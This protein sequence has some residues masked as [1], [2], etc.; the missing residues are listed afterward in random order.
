MQ[1]N[2]KEKNGFAGQVKDYVDLIE[3]LVYP[4]LSDAARQFRI[5]ELGYG[6][7]IGD[8][9]FY[10]DYPYSAGVDKLNEALADSDSR[11]GD[12]DDGLFR[13]FANL[14]ERAGDVPQGYLYYTYDITQEGFRCAPQTNLP[15]Q[16]ALIR[17]QIALFL[18][19]M[20]YSVYLE[21]DFLAPVT[22]DDQMEGPR[23][24]LYLNKILPDITN[25]KTAEKPHVLTCALVSDV[26]CTDIASVVREVYDKLYPM[27][28]AFYES[29]LLVKLMEE[30]R[31]SHVMAYQHSYG[32]IAPNILRLLDEALKAVS[33]GGDLTAVGE[34]LL[35]LK[36]ALYAQDLTL[37]SMFHTEASYQSAERFNDAHGFHQK[38]INEMLHYYKLIANYLHVPAKI[39][40]SD[41]NYDKRNYLPKK[42]DLLDIHL[43]LWNLWENACKAAVRK[44][45]VYITIGLTVTEEVYISFLSPGHLNENFYNFINYKTAYPGHV[46][47]KQTYKGL[48]IAGDKIIEKDWGWTAERLEEKTPSEKTL[49]TVYLT[50]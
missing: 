36:Q 3:L 21:E 20:H 46:N 38:T 15:D 9:Y 31:K 4:G 35:P 40:L 11:L 6:V 34:S 12:I 24:L 47:A 48:E 18:P 41:P 26:P 44:G 50:L 29:P 45:E 19:V 33:D 23:Y 43:V 25:T 8:D 14:Q 28:E 7:K 16:T 42:K 39:T 49:I 13:E 30:K 10:F 1:F 5:G 27:L 2:T 32:N 37:T 17:R 22:L